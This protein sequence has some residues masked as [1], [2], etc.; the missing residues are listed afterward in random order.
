MNRF[1]VY[2]S[3][4][5]FMPKDMNDVIEFAQDTPKFYISGA[6]L[7][8]CLQNVKAGDKVFTKKGNVLYI[9]RCLQNNLDSLSQEDQEY[10]EKLKR[11]YGLKNVNITSV[12]QVV[13]FE[14]WCK[15]AK[16]PYIKKTEEMKNNFSKGLYSRMR[17]MYMPTEVSNIR[18]STNGELAV[19]TDNGY[20]AI[21][22]QNQ[23][24]SYP[25]E[26][27][28]NLPVYTISKPKEQLQAGDVV[29]AGKGY[30]K[31]TK[32]EGDKISAITYTGA[33]KV[34]HTIKDFLFNQTM[35]RVVVSLVGMAGGQFNPMML[36]A[37][38]ESEGSMKDS[39]L[40]LMMMS[41]SGGN[42][43]A[44]PMMAALLMGGDGDSLSM[45]DVMMM[46]MISGGNC[47][48]GLFGQ[49][50]QAPA[51]APATKRAVRKPAKR[52]TKKAKDESASE[53]TE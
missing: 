16:Q 46:S 50:P 13:K 41:Q 51:P 4:L 22:A 48:G 24:I 7:N 35:V 20:V 26:L 3:N 11:E 25:R 28:L 18:V 29:V 15:S 42:I 23:L 53:V 39:L 49:T 10:L 32:V 2:T 34:I 9:I 44:N 33:G 52:S 30:A 43:M 21:D 14:T 5:P 27:T 8:T 12:E 6:E 17:E 37:M 19:E 40:P 1:L 47:F 36:M 38:S 45:K 31:V